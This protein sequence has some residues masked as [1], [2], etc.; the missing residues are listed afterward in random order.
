MQCGFLARRGLLANA[1]QV[2]RALADWRQW[3]AAG[4]GGGCCDGGSGKFLEEKMPYR[5]YLLSFKL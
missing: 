5:F 1:R 4:A 2:V 3:P